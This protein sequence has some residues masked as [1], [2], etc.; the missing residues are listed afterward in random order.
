MTDSKKNPSD[1]STVSRRSFLK[2]S[3]AVAAATAIQAHAAEAVEQRG[4]VVVSGQNSI[5]LNI[6]GENRE[7]TV[8]PRTTLLEVLRI[9]LDLTGAKPV[10]D[11]GI[12]GASTVLID[13]KPKMAS[14]TLA[15]QAVGKKIQ[16]VESFGGNNP[17]VKAF[18]KHD[19]QQ[20]GFCTP[21]FIVAIRAFLNKN[22]NASEQQIREGLNGNLCRCGTYQNIFQAALE[23]VKGD[24]K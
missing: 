21:G 5:T 4:P 1:K 22:P 24:A 10:S 8:E 18:V 15:M 6:N 12:S 16:T 2:G 13:G 14:T 7:V 9:Q 17:V 3:G 23:M 11:D 20:C 19:G